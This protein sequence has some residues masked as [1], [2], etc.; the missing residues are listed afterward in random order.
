MLES[1]IRHLRASSAH[2]AEAD[3]GSDCAAWISFGTEPRDVVKRR[4]PTKEKRWVVGGKL[5][6]VDTSSGKRTQFD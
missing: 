3:S 1:G 2:I 4:T 6:W 5:V